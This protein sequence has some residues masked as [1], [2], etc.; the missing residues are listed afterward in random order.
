MKK[1]GFTLIELLAV[2]VVLA[3]I[4]LIAVPVISKVVEKSKKAAAIDG[5]LG[6]ISAIEMKIATDALSGTNYVNKDD[7]VYDEIK[8]KA[9]GSL[10]TGGMYALYN[11]RVINA[12]FCISGYVV[13]YQNNKAT[14]GEKCEGEDLKLVSNLVVS[15]D[16]VSLI[17]P[18]E[19]EIEIIENT[20][21]GKLSCTT[22]NS[23]IATCEISGNKVIVKSGKKEGYTTITLTSKESSKYKKAQAAI[24][25]STEEGLLSV[26]ANGYKGIYDGNAHGISVI[27]SGATIKYG[28]VNGTYDLTSSPTYIN[29]GE[30]TVYYEVTKDGYKTVRGSKTIIIKEAVSCVLQVTEKGVSFVSKTP[31]NAE[32][33][34]N[35]TETTEYNNIN[36]LNLSIGTF[37]GYVKDDEGNV[38]SCSA[39]VT[40]TVQNWTS[41]QHVCRV[42][43]GTPYCP[44]G[45]TAYGGG[46]YS[47]FIRTHNYG[48]IKDNECYT[49]KCPIDYGR[50]G[51]G[52]EGAVCVCAT[53]STSKVTPKSYSWQG[54]YTYTQQ[55]SCTNNN[56]TCDASH[57]NQTRVSCTLVSA[58][59]SSGTK[60]N[61]SYC[62]TIN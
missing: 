47:N 7:Y 40:N 42:S 37:Y 19:E 12:K 11:G 51:I 23:S 24:L 25:V 15:K 8:A 52:Q 2:I 10:P 34:M 59:C 55:T 26:S 60:L 61:D 36:T 6:Y 13:D 38:G 41:T 30:Y 14:I 50:N 54:P 17:Y 49:V 56:I 57:V 58:T 29:A 28:T 35:K 43:S 33:G 22:N 31:S 4:A 53:G 9:K 16:N 62:Y 48:W 5:A 32:Y 45:Y 44:S 3:I 27:S 21:G 1:K 39:T 46:C 20:S 18:A